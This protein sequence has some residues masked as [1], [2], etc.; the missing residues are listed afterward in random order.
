MSAMRGTRIAISYH[1]KSYLLLA[2]AIKAMGKSNATAIE[3]SVAYKALLRIGTIYKLEGTLKSL[4]P[5]KRLAER[6]SSI[7]PLVE[8]YFVWAK[9]QLLSGHV[10]PK[11]ETAKGLSYSINQEDYLNVFLTDGEAPIDDS[12][13]ERALRNFTIGRKNWVTINTVRGAKAS[14]IIYSVTETARANNLNVYYYIKYLLT[15]LPGLIDKNGNIEQSLLEP[16]M[17]WSKTLPAD[18][19]SKRRK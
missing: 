10:L 7:K 14:A 15:E 6:Q 12:A 4:S 9:E 8:E 5:E 13:S 16:L 1:N 3:S 18:C 19:Y 2:N 17:P 11:S